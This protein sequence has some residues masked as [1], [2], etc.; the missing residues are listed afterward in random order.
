MSEQIKTTTVDQLPEATSLDGLY[1]FGYA[2]KNAVG[3]RSVKAPINLLKGN[4]GET[5]EAGKDGKDGE[6]TV[7]QLEE[8]LRG[9]EFLATEA[10]NGL[11]SANE[12][13][14]LNEIIES[15]K[16]DDEK[17]DGKFIC[18]VKTEEIGKLISLMTL[19][20]YSSTS[21]TTKVVSNGV[22]YEN[23][24]KT[25]HSI[26]FRPTQKE[27][28]IE[29]YFKGRIQT[30]AASSAVSSYMIVAKDDMQC[31]EVNFWYYK[32]D[33]IDFTN[34][35]S[36]TVISGAYSSIEAMTLNKAKSISTIN[37]SNSVKLKS[38]SLGGYSGEALTTVL[39]SNCPL[40]ETFSFG[41]D[42]KVLTSID[43]VGTLIT[44]EHLIALESKWASRVGK[45]RGLLKISKALYDTLTAETKNKF[46]AKDIDIQFL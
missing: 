9:D 28:L 31:V 5:G 2:S 24:N 36:F 45:Q 1:V 17:Y 18:F 42:L 39:L 16:T 41:S 37:M 46:L 14:Q 23:E 35:S 19:T 29:V 32:G 20:P 3:K 12:K 4:K 7:V 11:M 30:M 34:M 43:A 40:L 22:S 25:R 26:S 15:M 21:L 8:A 27:Q 44:E 13:K 33:S 10:T 38:I 6:V